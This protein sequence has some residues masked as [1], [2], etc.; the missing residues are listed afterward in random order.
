MQTIAALAPTS[1]S[2]RSH[3]LDGSPAPL[4]PSFTKRLLTINTICLVPVPDKRTR[5]RAAQRHSPDSVRNAIQKNKWHPD[6]AP[7]MRKGHYLDRRE[8]FYYT[9]V[10]LL[11]N[12]NIDQAGIHGGKFIELVERLAR[13]FM[14]RIAFRN[15]VHMSNIQDDL[16]QEAITKCCLVVTRFTPWNK[17]EPTKLNNAFA[18]FTTIIRNR[19][20]ETLDSSISAPSVYL[21]DLLGEDQSIGDLL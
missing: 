6:S 5:A 18:Y 10:I 8:L 4:T 14:G 15:S 12:G 3:R 7:A 13:N 11:H 19:M 20:F 1:S 2:F 21:D 9:C 17:L 16:I